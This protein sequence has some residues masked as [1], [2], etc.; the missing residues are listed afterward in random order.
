MHSLCGRF[1]AHL[2]DYFLRSNQS[3]KRL[4]IKWHLIFFNE[5]ILEYAESHS[6]RQ[7]MT[8]MTSLFEMWSGLFCQYFIIFRRSIQLTNGS[9]ANK[10]GI[11]SWNI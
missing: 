11:K 8:S 10:T 7:P 5:I 3:I 1:E 4:L 2:S 6:S 9:G